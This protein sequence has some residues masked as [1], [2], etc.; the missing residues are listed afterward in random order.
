[1]NSLLTTP[2]AGL[3]ANGEK[4]KT[5]IIEIKDAILRICIS[6]WASLD[7]IDWDCMQ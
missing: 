7:V 6:L 1:M 4:A 5:A 3:C 2:G